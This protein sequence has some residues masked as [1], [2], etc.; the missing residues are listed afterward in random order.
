MLAQTANQN[1]EG[2]A[3]SHLE[4]QLYRA[5]SPMIFFFP[6]LLLHALNGRNREGNGMVWYVITDTPR[7]RRRRRRTTFLYAWH[8]RP[9]LHANIIFTCPAIKE[10]IKQTNN[11]LTRPFFSSVH[12]TVKITQFFN[13]M[14]ETLLPGKVFLKFHLLL[15]A[16]RAGRTGSG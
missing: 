7:D 6:Y 9:S 11:N 8:G 14:H 10:N 16:L 3:C 1:G 4:V 15:H 13:K 5:C 12:E 2:F